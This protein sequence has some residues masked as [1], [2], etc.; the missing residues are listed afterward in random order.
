M[1]ETEAAAVVAGE[2][3]HDHFWSFGYYWWLTEGEGD[4]VMD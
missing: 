1:N 3:E 4:V 2:E